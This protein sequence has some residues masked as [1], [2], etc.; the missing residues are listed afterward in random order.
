[1]AP[2]KVRRLVTFDAKEWAIVSRIS[3]QDGRRG[4]ADW[5]AW[6]VRRELHRRRL[7]VVVG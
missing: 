2:H 6:L 3:A 4:A 5:V 7:L 1:M